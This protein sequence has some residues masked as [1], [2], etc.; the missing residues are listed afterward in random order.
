MSFYYGG[1]TIASNKISQAIADALS[2]KEERKFVETVEV[3]INLK[4]VD[5]QNPQKR[6]NAEVALPH[7]RGRPARVA[8]FAQG[9]MA[10]ISKKV[11]DTVISPEQI[12]ELSENKREARK[13]AGKFDFFVAETGLMAN[14]GKSLGVVLGPR[15]KMP[16]PIPPQADIERI[17]K[18]LTNL[19]PVRSKDRPTFH[20]PIGN[21]K[22]SQEQLAENLETILKR[23]ESSLDRGYDNIA[24]VWVKTTM[25]KS[26]RLE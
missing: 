6:I 11:V 8:V 16:R 17:I 19:V 20:V 5:L 18:S 13:L 4:D 15:G 2:S 26:V 24:S 7:G 9:E 3:A 23:V 21:V 12:D 22:M 14:I 25:G 1:E 10:V